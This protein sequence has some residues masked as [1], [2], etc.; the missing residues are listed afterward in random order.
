ML[1]NVDFGLRQETVGRTF[2]QI[3]QPGRIAATP[4]T[5]AEGPAELARALAEGRFGPEQLLATLDLAPPL[6]S[7]SP[8]VIGAARR[9]AAKPGRAEPRRHGRAGGG[10][11]ARFARG[12]GNPRLYDPRPG[13]APPD[14]PARQATLSDKNTSESRG[15]N[16]SPP[17]L[18]RAGCGAQ[19][20]AKTEDP[21]WIM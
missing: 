10:A 1:V 8:S 14:R 6:R 17:R 15:V 4:V 20:K 21:T 11:H 5:A 13:R 3:C 12:Q 19:F 2:V 16:C 7:L 9:R 18:R